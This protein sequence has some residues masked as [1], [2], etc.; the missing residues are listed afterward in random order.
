MVGSEGR[1]LQDRKLTSI[2]SF[3]GPEEKSHKNE[4]RQVEPVSSAI[5]QEE[6]HQENGAKTAPYLP[7]HPA[8]S[9]CLSL[10][11]LLNI[12]IAVVFG[13]A[14]IERYI[15]SMSVH[16]VAIYLIIFHFFCETKIPKRFFFLDLRT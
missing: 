4:L 2:G 15:P 10:L 11:I 5:L 6:Y 13:I 14:A 9:F 7:I 1:H 8:L 16:N 3:M 12:I